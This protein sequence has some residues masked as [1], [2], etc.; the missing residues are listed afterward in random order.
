[1]LKDLAD[2][3]DNAES[4]VTFFSDDMCLAD[5]DLNVRLRDDDSN[6]DNPENAIHIRCMAWCIRYK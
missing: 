1:M 3:E 2:A 5:V 6:N 4:N